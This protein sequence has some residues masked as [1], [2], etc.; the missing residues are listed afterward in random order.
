MKIIVII[1]SYVLLFKVILNMCS[2]FD[3]ILIIYFIGNFKV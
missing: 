2:D 3:E 1:Y